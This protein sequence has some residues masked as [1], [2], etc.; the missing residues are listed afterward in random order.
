M[1]ENN[2]NPL[3]KWGQNFLIDVNIIQFIVSFVPK[4]ENCTLVEI[5]P[6]LGS[7]TH[8]LADLYQEFHIF[9]IDP[10]YIQFLKTQN[11]IQNNQV[12]IHEGDVLKNYSNLQHKTLYIVGNLPYYITSD[13][14]SM[15]LKQSPQLKGGIFM[16]QREF[17]ERLCKEI[18][19]FSVFASFF[20]KFKILKNVNPRCFYPAPQAE[21]SIIQF[22]PNSKSNL[23]PIHIELVEL[24]LRTFFWGKRK[25]IFSSIKKAPFI[26]ES[27]IFKKCP[28][29]RD[30]LKESLTQIKKHSKQRP[31]ELSLTEYH[32]LIG[33]ASQKLNLVTT[34]RS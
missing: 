26:E 3:K 14:L 32:Q 6:G 27:S 28:Q 21:S 19:S 10:I 31:E 20:G 15:I 5:G 34:N 33:L 9:E 4:I 1:E 30:I 13:I 11:F 22:T 8:L 23:E 7:L 2:S 17:A 24:V 29:L 18:S 16:V 25:P 12:T